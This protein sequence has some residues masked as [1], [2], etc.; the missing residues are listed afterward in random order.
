MVHYA[1]THDNMRLAGES[2][3]WAKSRTRLAA[4]LSHNGC[5]GFTNGVEWY[6]TEKVNVHGSSG[7][8][9]G[10]EE[11]MISEI[12]ELNTLLDKHPCFP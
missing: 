11:N 6:A 5:F 8:R 12:A 9:W 1:E 10:S 3:L 4:L 2:Q 7:L